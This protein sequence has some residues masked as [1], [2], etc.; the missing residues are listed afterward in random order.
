M[1]MT[2]CAVVSSSG[3]DA[4]ATPASA[5]PTP[6]PDP[7]PTPTPRPTPSPTHSPTPFDATVPPVRPAALDAPFSAGAAED[8]AVYLLELMPYVWATGE[9]A[10]VE[11]L[12]ATECN[13]CANLVES[14]RD[15]VDRGEHETGN[16]VTVDNVDA[17]LLDE[18]FLAYYDYES[19]TAS[20]TVNYVLGP[21][22]RLDA[23]GEVVEEDRKYV[24]VNAHVHVTRVDG[25]WKV[26]AAAEDDVLESDEPIS[27]IRPAI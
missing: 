17:D 22:T 19:P 27:S 11:A 16:Q 20:V 1:A 7:A 3:P 2:G 4:D 8:V 12:T 25:A 10:E 6:V 18:D 21:W 9:T 14:A 13:F 5:A 23:R 26:I 24:Y 15:L